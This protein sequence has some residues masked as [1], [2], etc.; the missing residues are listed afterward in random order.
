M[1]WK[2]KWRHHS[3]ATP[4]HSPSSPPGAQY[5]DHIITP[6]IPCPRTVPCSGSSFNN[7]IT[8]TTPPPHPPPPPHTPITIH[9]SSSNT[10]QQNHKGGGGLKI[11]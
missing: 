8:P 4:I 10:L 1:F 3:P 6:P 7:S 11:P 5:N 2:G 9:F